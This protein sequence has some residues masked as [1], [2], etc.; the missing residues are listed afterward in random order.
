M[1]NPYTEATPAMGTYL[2]RN[3]VEIAEVTNI[4]GPSFSAETIEATHLRSPGFWREHIGGVKD[5]GELTF[6]INMLLTN[7]THN[8]ATGVL[9]GFNSNGAATRD[10]WD[11][12]FPD[13]A[14]TVWTLG[15]FITGYEVSDVAI[16]GKLSASVTVK[17]SGKPTLA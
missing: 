2:R 15:G 9:A 8:A 12:V 10:V 5:G 7:P 13:A 4:G 16:D 3:G 6:D 1:A 17:I 14:N 11:L